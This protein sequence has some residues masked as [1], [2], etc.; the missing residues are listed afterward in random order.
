MQG[1]VSQVSIVMILRAD[2][3][4][5]DDAVWTYRNYWASPGATKRY[6]LVAT[7]KRPVEIPITS[8]I[9]CN[10]ITQTIETLPLTPNLLL[11]HRPRR[12]RNA[13]IASTDRCG[14]I[15]KCR[16]LADAICERASKR[17][18][19]AIVKTPPPFPT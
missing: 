6:L 3:C 8:V 5:G 16:V 2:R 10:R 9:H 19:V 11:D 4:D 1:R 7:L 15:A 14:E 18:R 12:I 13:L 17:P